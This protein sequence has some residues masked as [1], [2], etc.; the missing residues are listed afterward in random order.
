MDVLLLR[1]WSTNIGNNFIEEGAKLWIEG[2]IENVAI[3]EVGGYSYRASEFFHS[4]IVS[5]LKIRGEKLPVSKQ[6]VK[7]FKRDKRSKALDKTVSVGELID[8]NSFDLAI[9][10]GCVLEHHVF[11]KYEKVL[12]RLEEK[13]IP[14]II[15]GAGSTS[16]S[17]ETQ[18]YVKEQL[19][20]SNIRGLISR[21]PRAYSLYKDDVEQARE[22]I[23]A[24]FFIGDY[25]Q[26]PEAEEEFVAMTYDKGDEYEIENSK[27]VVRPDHNPFGRPF[28]SI[29]SK[30][31]K[32]EV[33][34]EHPFDAENVF[35]SDNP[36]D[37]LFIYSNAEEVYSDRVHACLPTLV[38]GNT[39]YFDHDTPRSGVFE[40]VFEEDISN[41]K[42]ELDSERLE[43]KKEKAV[44][45]LKEIVGEIT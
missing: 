9:L 40:A 33:K 1:T 45:D 34:D 2:A 8:L 24:A 3:T 6:R 10:P 30:F 26:P 29:S 28:G 44:S 18:D 21:N 22:G 19:E 41:K 13:N 7:D 14:V 23:D 32:P 36:K 11:G 27:M 38:Y 15:L 42:V 31:L 16:Y 25:Y 12:D 20:R 35:V 37:Y 43:N 4:S 39:A 17:K 5:D